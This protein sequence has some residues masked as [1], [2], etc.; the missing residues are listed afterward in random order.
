MF[1]G[2]TFMLSYSQKHEKR[3]VKSENRERE[4]EREN[5]FFKSPLMKSEI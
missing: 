2:R 3:K 5:E 1:N 4:K